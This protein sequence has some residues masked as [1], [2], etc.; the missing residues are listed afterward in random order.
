MSVY[1]VKKDGLDCN[2][3]AGSYEKS[4]TISDHAEIYA[5]THLGARNSLNG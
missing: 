1:E 4:V 3:D 2:R 5:A